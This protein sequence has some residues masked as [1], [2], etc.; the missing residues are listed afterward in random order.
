MQLRI[1]PSGGMP[2]VDESPHADSVSVSLEPVSA[3]DVRTYRY[4]GVILEEGSVYTCFLVIL[5][6][7]AEVLCMGKRIREAAEH[8]I[9]GLENLLFKKPSLVSAVALTPC[10]VASYGPEALDYFL[11]NSPQMSERI[12]RSVLHQ[13]LQTTQKLAESDGEF[14]LDDVRVQFYQDREVIIQEGVQ[15]TDFYKLVSSD[16]GLRVSIRGEEVALISKP[17]EFF[18]EMASLLNLTRQ[19]TVSS[20]GQS[21]VQVYSGDQ[22]GMLLEEHPDVA[23]RMVRDLASRLAEINRKLMEKTL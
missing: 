15:G 12:L 2:M 14:S 22:L 16:G 4:G 3:L 17:G 19:A 5:S 20:I 7:Q 18:G 21:V 6:G 1:I 11:H 8:D 9:L 13:L 23:L 10:R